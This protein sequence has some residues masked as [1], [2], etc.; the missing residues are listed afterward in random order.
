MKID[1]TSITFKGHSFDTLKPINW[2]ENRL[3]TQPLTQQPAQPYR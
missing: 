3:Q 1:P 2:E